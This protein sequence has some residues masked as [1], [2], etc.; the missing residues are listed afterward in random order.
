M[1]SHTRELLDIRKIFTSW[2]SRLQNINH[3]PSFKQNK[4]RKVRVVK[5]EIAVVPGK[6]HDNK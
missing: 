2:D 5:P 6:M 3:T 1:A 4:S